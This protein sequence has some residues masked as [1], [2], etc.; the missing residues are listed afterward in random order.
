MK[1]LGNLTFRGCRVGLVTLIAGSLFVMS[2]HPVA[3]TLESGKDD[4]TPPSTKSVYFE[5]DVL[6][7]F[8]TNCIRCHGSETRIKEMNLSLYEGV[9]KGSESGPVVIPGKPE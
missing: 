1:T 6:P 7:I 2:G 8:N 3:S 5:A 4:R 9:M